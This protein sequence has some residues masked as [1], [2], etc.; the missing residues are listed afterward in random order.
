MK[1]AFVYLYSFFPYEDANTVATMPMIQRLRQDFDVEIAAFDREGHMP[2][3]GEYD[4]MR[5]SWIKPDPT[6]VNK[7][8]I[9]AHAPLSDKRGAKRAALSFLRPMSRLALTVRGNNAA[10]VIAA[11]HAEMHFD[12]IVTVSAPIDTVYTVSELKR[13]GQLDGCRWLA[14]FED[15]YAGYIGNSAASDELYADMRR[16]LAYAD[17]ISLT[18]E[19]YIARTRELCDSLGCPT[20]AIPV[21]AIRELPT[22]ARSASDT[23][24][25]AYIGSLQNIAVR[26]PENMFRIL[27][28]AKGVNATLVV[29]AFSDECRALYDKL[30][31]G[32]PAVTLS[33]RISHDECIS[34]V[35]GS[36]IL[37]NIGNRAENQIPSKLF[38]Y[39][40]SG[41]PIVHFKCAADD[42]AV[43]LL[44]RYPNALVLCGAGKDECERFEKFCR[45]RSGVRIPFDEVRRLFPEYTEE[46][47]CESFAKLYRRVM[48]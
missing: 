21:S 34:L 25:C 27:A 48:K 39:I 33:G 4:G 32:N 13:R 31:R 17:G 37:L 18:P 15:P 44:E 9:W 20:V 43:P 24:R 42:P 16:V 12:L 11:H 14:V 36:D 10:S 30:L 5:V 26:N 41:L 8:F 46:A 22:A 29:S 3:A 28:A 2:A 38:E 19:M 35:G 1:R 7:A 45:E 23:A 47:I 6:P 40:S